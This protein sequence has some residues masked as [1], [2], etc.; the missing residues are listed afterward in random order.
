MIFETTI[1]EKIK[2]YW[3]WRVRIVRTKPT[4]NKQRWGIRLL[5]FAISARKQF[6]LN[7]KLFHQVF[8]ERIKLPTIRLYTAGRTPW[9][10]P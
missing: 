5:L 3:L 1:S 10:L 2:Y 7:S 4:L 9:I 8:F 6:E